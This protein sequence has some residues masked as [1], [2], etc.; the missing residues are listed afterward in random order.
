M[1]TMDENRIT[2]RER[3]LPWALRGFVAVLGL[4]VGLG[5]PA[6]WLANVGTQTGWPMLA[7]VA[8]VVLVCGALGGF[9]LLLTLVSATEL[10]ID[11]CLL[12]TSRCV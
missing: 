4:G 7:L 1:L 10:Q 11:P 6:S 3:P 9:F 8:A 2:Y 5:I 12:Y